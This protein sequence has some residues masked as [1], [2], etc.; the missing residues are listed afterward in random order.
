VN[1]NSKSVLVTGAG[2]FIGSHLTEA[3]VKA[4]A[5]T[6]AMVRYSST[7]H[8]GW[9][10]QSDL[11]D[12]MEIVA[13]DIREVDSVRAALKGIEVV[14]HLA[15]LIAIPYSYVSPSSYVTTNIGGILN[16]L[17]EALSAGVSR[18]EHPLQAQSP[19]SATKIG[20][21]KLAESFYRSFDLP[22]SIIRPFNTYGPRQSARA[23]IPTI[24]TQA[25]ENKPIHVGNVAPTRDFNFVE[26]T[27][28]GFMLNAASQSAVG[29][30]IN[31][32]SGKEISI[33][34]LAKL[35]CCLA[36]VECQIVRDEQRIR[37]L[38]SE[39]ERLCAD[40]RLAGELLGWR[41]QVGLRDGLQKT[42]DWLRE[43]SNQ[44][45][46]GVYAV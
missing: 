31:L 19:Y 36:G 37:P 7:G 17:Q 43:N 35:I 26:D 28:R 33:G 44:Y 42:L 25:L 13:G 8:R 46:T 3:L 45:R 14:F 38:G 6:R 30:V 18:V 16:L 20:A 10:E 2:G 1:W 34:E 4:G 11:K 40:N 24:M 22:V 21:D 12:E 32:G 41:P 23:I 5:R 39:V 9:L 27:V 29:R 15:A